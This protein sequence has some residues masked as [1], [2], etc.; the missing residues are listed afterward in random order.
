MEILETGTPE[1]TEKTTQSIWKRINA[2]FDRNFALFFAPFLVG[3]L[4]ITVLSMMGVAPFGNKY[5]AASY[6]LS[7]Q[8]CPFVE[9]LFDVLQ[10]KSTLTYSYAIVGGADVTGTFLYFFISP[11]SFLFLIF[12]DGKVAH[13]SSIVMLCKLMAIAFSGT[14]F[15]K[16]QFKNIPDYLCIVIGCVYAYCGYMFVAN[17]YINWMDFIIYMPFCA[18]AFRHYVK[19]GKFLPFS[20]LS[21]CCIYTCFSIA[22]FSLFTVFPALVAYGLICVDKEKKMRFIAYMALSF[23]V[24]LLIALPVL[25]PA[26]GAFLRSARGGSIFEN[27]WKGYTVSSEGVIGEFDSSVFIESYSQSLYRKWSYIMADSVFVALTVFWFIRMGLKNKFAQFMLVAAVMTLLP[28]LVDEAMNLMN[29]GSYMSYALRFGFLNA[30]YFLGGACLAIDGWCYDKACAYDGKP[31]YV[32]LLDDVVEE[33]ALTEKMENEGGRYVVNEDNTPVLTL[34]TP[35]S[36]EVKA[37]KVASYICMGVLAVMAVFA[38]VI[39]G[40]L[41]MKGGI[42]AFWSVFIKDEETLG[43]L[44]GFSARLA[45]SLGGAEAIVIPFVFVILITAIGC[46]MAALRKIS[47]RFLTYI[48]IGVVGMQ[49]VFYNCHLISGNASTQHVNIGYYQEISGILNEREDQYFRLKDYNDKLTA[50]VPFTG[51]ANSFSVFSSVIDEDNFATFQMF[52]YLGNGKNSFKSGHNKGR[53]YRAE[54]FGDSFMGYKYFLFYADPNNKEKTVEEQLSELEKSKTYLQRVVELDENGELVQLKRG[55]FYVYENTVVFPSGYRVQG[56]SFRFVSENT[57]N[58]ANRKNNQAAL[59][60]YLRGKELLKFTKSDTVTVKSAT[61]LSEYL[62]DRA[63]DV[64]V[65]AG[66]IT[67]RVTAEEGEHLLLNFVASKGYKATVNGKP[68]KL[69]DNDLK[70]LSVALEEGKNEVVFTY[71]SPY[72]E[73]AAIGVCGGA[74]SLAFVYLVLKKTSIFPKLSVLVAWAAIAVG[75]A[76]V[77]FFMVYP[78]CVFTVKLISLIM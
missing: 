21:A 77:A 50:C 20:I 35:L 45:H 3:C 39:I 68:V 33:P 8:I 7:A 32:K 19:T 14:W 43:T 37:K 71:S 4:Y 60:E 75:V 53:S 64:E 52:G 56:E 46:F 58:G 57:N 2:F 29:M 23:V 78:T 70:F 42:K 55:N 6:D 59:Y 62:W 34:K 36:K 5:T 10:G 48:L 66:T 51:N 72:V 27:L 30:L 9:H 25:L 40:L 49:V 63:A 31:L 54:V 26:L 22:C 47:P 1:Q 67:A 74:L 76:V 38:M 15:A 11:F 18:A 69:L 65:G 12:G 28:L 24:A 61:E 16:T 17:T 73:Y 41:C 44:G 13:A